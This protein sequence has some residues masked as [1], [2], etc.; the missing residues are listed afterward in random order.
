MRVS[1]C[2]WEETREHGCCACLLSRGSPGNT[3]ASLFS[4]LCSALHR[5]CLRALNSPPHIYLYL[6]KQSS[7][8]A[9]GSRE[10]FLN[11]LETRSHTVH[12]QEPPRPWRRAV[13]DRGWGWGCGLPQVWGGARPPLAPEAFGDNS[14]AVSSGRDQ[15][16]PQ[17]GGGSRAS[18][19]CPLGSWGPSILRDSTDPTTL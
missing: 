3:V 5:N 4:S 17:W 1:V 9:V 18:D 6:N 14:S 11:F 13:R 19:W 12:S 16:P 7:L 15:V 2:G 8:L 10:M